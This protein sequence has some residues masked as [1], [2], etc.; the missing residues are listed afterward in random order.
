MNQGREYY[1]QMTIILIYQILYKK[2]RYQN[3]LILSYGYDPGGS[4]C[5]L[6]STVANI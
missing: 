4:K 1:N 6:L 5:I 3:S 2:S